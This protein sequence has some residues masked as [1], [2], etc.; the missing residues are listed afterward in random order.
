MFVCD[1]PVR[2]RRQK[3]VSRRR[4]CTTI[5]RVSVSLPTLLKEKFI[6]V[7]FCLTQ[8]WTRNAAHYFSSGLFFFFYIYIILISEELA[9]QS[10]D[11]AS[12]TT[13]S[14]REKK[15]PKWGQDK[16]CPADS[17]HRATSCH[18]HG[19]IKAQLTLLHPVRAE[20]RTKVVRE[21]E[22]FSTLFSIPALSWGWQEARL[23]T[24]ELFTRAR[25]STPHWSLLLELHRVEATWQV[26]EELMKQSVHGCQNSV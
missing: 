14:E 1:V 16:W 26:Q 11:S 13:S 2:R 4:W 10:T 24:S 8:N 22:L 17:D 12:K 18:Q 25:H 23:S 5:T 15:I 19:V 3:G 20:F 9:L 6:K 7:F 21:V